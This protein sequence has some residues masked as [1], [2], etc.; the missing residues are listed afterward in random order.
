M[1][2]TNFLKNTYNGN[3]RIRLKRLREWVY[4]VH[5]LTLNGQR[6]KKIISGADDGKEPDF[7]CIF[8]DNGV[9][10]L[11]GIELTT[12]P[13]LRDG[14]GDELLFPRRWYWQMLLWLGEPFSGTTVLNK[15]VDMAQKTPKLTVHSTIVQDDITAVM[16]K[17]ADKVAAYNTR[18][19]LDELWLLIHT[20]KVQKQGVLMGANQQLYHTSDY[21]RIVVTLYPTR[22]LIDISKY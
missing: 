7:S 3:K 19:T 9:D 15:A 16:S 1:R 13:R 21:D 22:E 6:P 17:K 10:K 12:L 14:L 2:P 8:T 5:F 20:D 11:V 4:L 18:R